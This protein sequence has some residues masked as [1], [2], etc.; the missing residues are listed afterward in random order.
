M[1]HFNDLYTQV[2]YNYLTLHDDS[3]ILYKDLM[4]KYK[5]SYP[6][7]RKRIKWLT[8]NGYI[9]KNRRHIQIIPQF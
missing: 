2:I 4:H 3:I 7:I 9:K 6:T 5:M 8:D 1:I